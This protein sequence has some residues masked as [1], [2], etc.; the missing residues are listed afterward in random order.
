MKN[1]FSAMSVRFKSFANAKR[2]DQFVECLI[3][4]YNEVYFKQ[5]EPPCS[6]EKKKRNTYVSGLHFHFDFVIYFV[7]QLK[8][9]F[10]RDQHNH[11]I[12]TPKMLSK[13]I[14]GLKFYPQNFFQQ[15]S[16]MR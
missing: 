3:E 8:A 6:G 4:L 1:Q 13:L 7:R 2:I 5:S 12:F 11:Y 16:E 14:E 15:V 9:H 10:T